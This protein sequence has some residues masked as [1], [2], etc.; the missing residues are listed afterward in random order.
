MLLIINDVLPISIDPNWDTREPHINDKVSYVAGCDSFLQPALAEYW[1]RA[2]LP[3]PKAPP[4]AKA[5]SQEIAPIEIPVENN[6]PDPEMEGINIAAFT[7]ASRGILIRRIGEDQ[8]TAELSRLKELIRKGV[9]S[10]AIH[11][12]PDLRQPDDRVVYTAQDYYLFRPLQ[13]Y[14]QIVNGPSQHIR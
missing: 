1:D 7:Q 2:G 3:A 5:E 9:P 13:T 12:N 14:W 11:K 6:P 4:P 8:R 10:R